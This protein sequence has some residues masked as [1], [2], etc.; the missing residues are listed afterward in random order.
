MAFQQG[1]SGL[2]A[3]SKALDVIS[4]N[5]ANGGT[6]GFKSS[7]VHFSDVFANS[8]QGA[9]AAQIGIGAAMTGVVQQF[10]QG[11]I[12]TTN[13]PLDLSIN[14]GGF[15]RMSNA[16]TVTYSRNGQFHLDKNG[17]VVNDAGLR[18]TGYA[19]DSTGTILQSTPVD[20]QLDSSAQPPVAT[21]ASIGGTFNGVRGNVNLDA[22]ETQ[23]SSPWAVGGTG[24]AW[25]PN[26][27]TYNYSTAVSIYDSLGFAHNLAFYFV[28]TA[29]PGEWDVHANVDGTSDSYVTISAGSPLQFDSSGNLVGTTVPL[30]VSIDLDGVVT[31]STG[32]ANTNSATTPLTFEVDLAGSTQYGSGFSTNRLEQDGYAAGSL[33]GLSVSGDGVIQ[34][35]YSNGQ[36]RNLAQVVLANFTN[37]NGLTA[38]GANQWS[39]TSASGPALLGAPNSGSLGVLQSAAVEASNVD[40]T[41]ELV[42]MITQQRNYQAN[43][44]SIKTQD[45]VMQTLVNLR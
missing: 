22:R 41:A 14:G 35:R 43:A 15:F 42:A 44:Q 2:D 5:V 9:G 13:N 4:N 8:L 19:A 36:T 30:Q 28:K 37:P 31:D 27:Q 12:T 10:T 1:L 20:V 40:L 45:S 25:S 18:M 7:S 6:V 23:P 21:G 34:G 17:Y 16:G 32:G 29:N 26:P 38:L 33:A 3:A 11:N 24:A 39:E